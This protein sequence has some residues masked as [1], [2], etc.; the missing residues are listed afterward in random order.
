MAAAPLA[1]AEPVVFVA[2]EVL[3]EDFEVGTATIE[4]CVPE[5]AEPEPVTTT[6]E[7]EEPAAAEGEAEVATM[8][9]APGRGAEVAEAVAA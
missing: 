3:L 4:D 5:R 6:A 7:P 2:A 1:A 9:V 8:V